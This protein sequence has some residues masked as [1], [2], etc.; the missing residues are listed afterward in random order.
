MS[1]EEIKKEEVAPAETAS[2]ALPETPT[3]TPTETP[4]EEIPKSE[5]IETPEVI[6]ETPP[7]E[8]STPTE[9]VAPE[10]PIISS[11]TES[12]SS[13]P[14]PQPVSSESFIKNLL[15]KARERLQFRKRQKLEKILALAQKKG[16]ITN[17]DVEKLLRVSHKTA[18]RYLEILEKENRIRQ[19]GGTGR[20]VYYQLL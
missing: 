3:A 17:D 11:P 4:S 8:E 10:A 20:G 19:V 9:P 12:P 14:Q 2:E 16:R 13:P 6:P 5:P 1:E 7:I 18:S 15:V